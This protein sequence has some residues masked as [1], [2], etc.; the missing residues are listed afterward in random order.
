MVDLDFQ[1]GGQPGLVER[2]RL[3]G[4]LAGAGVLAGADAVFN[5]GV[6]PV[7]GV[8]AGKLAAPSGGAAGQVGHPQGVA[9]AVAASNK[10]SWAPGCGHAAGHRPP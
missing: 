9:P 7:R 6:H 8:D 1:R 4:K 5:P 2:E 10:V 3:A